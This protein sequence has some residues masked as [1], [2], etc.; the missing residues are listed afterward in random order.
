[1]MNELETQSDALLLKDRQIKELEERLT[2]NASGDSALLREIGILFPELQEFS[3][4]LQRVY[5]TADSTQ[6]VV[7]VLLYKSA[8]NSDINKLRRWLQ[9]KMARNDIELIHRN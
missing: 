8:N 9:Q 1:M 4:G 2:S 7:P 5:R 6:V 3:F